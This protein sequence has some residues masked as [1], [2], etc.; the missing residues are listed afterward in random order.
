M[1][2]A[3]EQ[4]TA[5]MRSGRYHTAWAIAEA[6]LRARDP[7]TRD[8]PS[9]PFHQ[10][11]VW[12]GSDPQGRD[13][14]VRC[15]HGLGDTIQFARYL[16]ILAQRARSLTVE[17]QPRLIALLSG[18]AG[19]DRLVPF[20]PARPLPPAECDIEI[21]ELDLVLRVAPDAVAAPYLR[22]SRA[23]LPR[24]TLALCHAA[25]DWDPQRNIPADLLE[26]ICRQ[27]PTLTLVADASPLPVLNPAGCPFDM[28]VTAA[29]VATAELVIT[30]DTM[31]A[32]LAG[33][34]GRPTWLLLKH[35]PDWRWS[36]HSR[37]SP[38]YPSMRL[39]AQP[40]PG[41]WQSVADAAIADFAQRA[42]L[43]AES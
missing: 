34:M 30:V 38:W 31:I 32:H 1:S 21:T 41:D 11:W 37:T 36:P 2:D 33:A 42:L 24:H 43:T 6:S 16:P 18:I 12:D 3:L 15:Y 20:D 39:Y 40:H 7:A 25:G 5:A 10:R 17:A 23:I 22:A 4:W 19:I 35:E 14:L 27:A 28:A 26:P 9:L 13:V 29:F 8:D